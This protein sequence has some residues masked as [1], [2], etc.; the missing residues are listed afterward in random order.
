MVMLAAMAFMLGAFF[1]QGQE[2]MVYAAGPDAGGTMAEAMEIQVNK[3][4][5]EVLDTEDDVDYFKFTSTAHGYFQVQL[6]HN[7]ANDTSEGGWEVNVLNEKGEALTTGYGITKTWTSIVLPYADPGRIFYIQV[8]KYY[9][10]AINSIYD[11]TVTQTASADWESEPNETIAAAN[12][13]EVNHTYHGITIN[14]SDTDYFQFKT[15]VH[16][17]F[18]VMLAHSAENTVSEGGWQVSVLN[19]KGE[20]LTTGY[21][22]TKTWT[23]IVLPYADPGR[24]FYIRVEK[25]Y[26]SAVNSVYDLT[27]TQTASADWESESNET[28]AE[29]SAISVNHTYHGITESKYDTDFFRFQTSAQ[30]YF[31]VQL[32]HNETN[33]SNRGGWYINVLDETGRALTS[34]TGIT[35]NWTSVILPYAKPGRVF[36]I[37]IGEYYSDAV[38]SVYDLKVVQKAAA[39]WESEPNGTAKAATSIKSGKT[40]HGITGARGDEDFYK[41]NIPAS[42]KISVKLSS[43]DTNQISDIGSGWEVVVYD[44]KL[45][46]VAGLNG[47]AAEKAFSL[48]VKKG[49]YYI[50][51]KGTYDS[52]A[53]FCRYAL[54]ANFVKAPAKPKISSVKAG[55]RTATVK[56]KKIQGVNGYYVYRSAFKKSGY[57]KVK[58]L[59][60]ASAV[61]YTN[62]K[63]KSGRTYYYRIAAYKKGKGMTVISPYSAVKSVKV[64]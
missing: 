10:S 7:S 47:I 49:I 17:Y 62:K 42:G 44:R 34:G 51:V 2:R 27:V 21:G 30:G 26:S 39:N 60:S 25:Y 52:S 43:S 38:K 40:Y 6:A 8:E 64:K 29:A 57:K 32:A 46:T 1:L 45:N 14:S 56:W 20:A 41:L 15:N 11:L 33:I 3:T 18:Q 59:K 13:I 50:K 19:E 23:S 55:K 35:K 58:T 28:M 16:G 63:L 31:Q 37:Q 22:I 36:Y 24:I 4:Y 48:D 5:S 54:S 9:S 53:V 61:S 12:P